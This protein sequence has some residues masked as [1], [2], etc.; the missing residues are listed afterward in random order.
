METF[1]IVVLG[2]GPVGCEVSQ[3]LARFGSRVTLVELSPQLLPSENPLVS[4]I[5]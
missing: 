1:D 2:G 4:G 3:V 5:L